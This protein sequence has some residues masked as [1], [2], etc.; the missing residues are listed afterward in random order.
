MARQGDFGQK[1]LDYRTE[2]MSF[3]TASNATFT[4]NGSPILTGASSIVVQ[5][6]GAVPNANASSVVGRNLTL[7]PASG[8]LPGGVSTGIQSFGG[9]KTFVSNVTAQSN[10][11]LPATSTA[12]AGLILRGGV[13]F[14][15]APG[16]NNLFL[17]NAA[18]NI[19]VTGSRNL[20]IGSTAARDITTGSSNVSIGLEAGR[21]CTIG[22]EN[23]YIGVRAGRDSLDGTFNVSVGTDTMPVANGADECA[24]I[25]RRSLFALTTGNRN[26]GLGP[27]TLQN[28]TTGDN[29]VALGAF[30]GQNLTGA[31][32][33]NVMLANEG[34]VGDN[35]TIRI[36]NANHTRNFTRGISGVAVAAAAPVI[37][38][39]VGQ[40][41]TV[42]SAASRKR[43]IQDIS[44]ADV[45]RYLSMR[46]RKFK[47]NGDDT[48]EIH[49]G[50]VVDESDE[51]MPELSL[52]NE[53][54]TF[55]AFKYQ[56]TDG[57]ILASLRHLRNRIVALESPPAP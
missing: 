23:T 3:Q 30:A 19:D 36:G 28:I 57:L 53:D 34:I 51:F 55:S 22:D 9:A 38:N 7:Q 15:Q 20:G 14:M 49:Y 13:T 27:Y 48:D 18:G 32:T 44:T 29:N 40:L 12:A 54:G 46:A 5:P 1:S 41:G 10:L 31:D 35:G 6:F 16:T 8:V 56:E 39:A 24:A 50:V 42:V 37:C 17:G 21:G 4:H 26:A 2:A 45:A 25:G 43:D 11:V 33:W 47:M 52:F